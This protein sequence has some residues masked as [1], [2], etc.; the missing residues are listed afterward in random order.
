MLDDPSVAVLPFAD[1]SGDPSQDYL[2]DGITEDIISG[3]AYFSELSV[4]AR[5]SSFSY[6]GR[7]VDVREV[8]RQLGAQYIVEGSVRRFGDRIRIT[9]QLVDSVSGVRRWAERFDRSVAD[10]FAIQDEITQAIVRIVVAHVGKAEL[11][12]V[13][14]KVPGSWTAYELSLRGDHAQRLLEQTWDPQFL[15]E[16]RSRFDEALKADPDNAKICSKLAHTYVRAYADAGSPDLGSKEL[17]GGSELSRRAVGLDPNLPLARAA[18]LDL[19]LDGPARCR[20]RRIRKGRRAQFEF[21]RLSFC[22]G[23]GFCGSTG[24]GAACPAGPHSP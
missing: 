5:N 24:A 21:C 23:A 4:I 7:A 15:Y 1:L 12:R 11:E 14:R 18:R 9:A 3:L 6:K 10:I 16:A 8:G 19:F 22:G 2:S 20:D 13:M 17:E